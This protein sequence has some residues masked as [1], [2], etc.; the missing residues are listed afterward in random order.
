M[1]RDDFEGNLRDEVE[2]MVRRSIIT[3]E[4]SAGTL[5]S[6]PSLAAQFAVSATPVREAM[7]NLQERGF[8][9]PVRNKGFRVTEVSERDL[10]EITVL[11]AWLEA[12]AMR[13]IAAVFPRERISEFRALADKIVRC[14]DEGDLG[15]HIDADLAFHRALLGLLGNARLVDLVTT[16]SQQTRMV[17]LS[18]LSATST[19]RQAATEH[20]MMLDRL[21]DGDGPGVEELVRAH[22]MRVIPAEDARD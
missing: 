11:H 15:G 17:G 22:I 5:V 1:R 16:L 21:M 10:R 4:L 12:P 20:H 6:V 7:V 8:V 3:G 19:L 2:Q 18:V 13:E 9:E 14:V